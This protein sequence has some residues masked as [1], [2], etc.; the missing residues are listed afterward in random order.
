VGTEKSDAKALQLAAHSL[1]SSSAYVGDMHLSALAKEL[2]M[3]G[4]SGTLEGALERAR[5]SCSFCRCAYL[6]AEKLGFTNPSMR[7][8][9]GCG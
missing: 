3:T 4:R 7:L 1:K 9:E 6:T 8:M 5:R 2:E